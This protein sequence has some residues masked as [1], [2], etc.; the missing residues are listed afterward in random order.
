MP[1]LVSPPLVVTVR[2]GYLHC[3]EVGP[4]GPMRETGRTPATQR[5]VPHDGN[6]PSPHVGHVST[7][8][9]VDTRVS[10]NAQMVRL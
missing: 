10:R 3:L 8:S 7:E 4:A 1:S 9:A 2:G 6:E 5:N